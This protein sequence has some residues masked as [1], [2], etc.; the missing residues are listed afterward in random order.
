[1]TR[2]E[3]GLAAAEADER[4]AWNKLRAHVPEKC[5]ECQYGLTLYRCA[6]HDRLYSLW[7]QSRRLVEA[8]MQRRHR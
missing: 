3:T 5:A 8:F 4:K 2:Y 7:C 1:M 6:R